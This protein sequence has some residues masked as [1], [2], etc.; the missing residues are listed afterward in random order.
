MATWRVLVGVTLALC[1]VVPAARG[2]ESNHRYQEGDP[3]KLW[4]NR[5]GP[6]HNPQ[7]TY[8]YYHLPFCRPPGKREHKWGG[9]GE[10]LEGNELIQSG[11][12]ITFQRDLPVTPICS[13]DVTE[14]VRKEFR[15]AVKE[16]YWYQM[17]FD[18]L[19]I[20][21]MVGELLEATE[22]KGPEP[23][24]FTHK[25]FSIAYNQ[26][27]IIEVNLTSENPQPLSSASKLDFTYQVRWVPT[28]KRF[29]AR[30]QRYLDYNFFEHQIH[31][32]SIFNSFMMVIFLTGLVSLILMRTLRN[33]YTRYTKDVDELDDLDHEITDESGWKL[34]H[35]DVFRTPA[36]PIFFAVLLGSGS[37][38][39]LTAFAVILTAIVGTLYMG[40]GSLTTSYIVCFSILSFAAGYAGGSWYSQA[41]GRS[42]IRVMVLTALFYP[43]VCFT[44]AFVLNFVAIAYHSLAALPFG[45]IVVMVMIWLFVSL[46]MC[47]FG[48]V[49]GRNWSGSVRLPCRVNPIPRPIPEKKWYLKPWVV[50]VLGGILPFGSIFIEMYFIFTSFWNYKFYYVYGFMLLVYVILVIVTVCVT[51]VSSYFLLN[52]EDYRWPWTSFLSAASTAVYVYAYAVYYFFMKTKMFGFFQTCFYFGYMG[53]F[54]IGLALMCGAIGYVGTRIFVG[55]IYRNIKSD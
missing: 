55:R 47:A 30:F 4:V 10:V 44:I 11:I 28:M 22:E 12:P 24:L 1:L 37:Q 35:G 23:L 5:V 38:L 20:W 51:I 49:M 40:R 9:L 42:W 32:F 17:Y 26:D 39:V 21:G 6:Y 33:D 31:W 13:L 2:D 46:P 27:R 7:E 34:V 16:H 3:V 29:G 19:P 48:T 45:S 18:D 50:T 14:K 36:H 41:G 53:M 25:S 15:H 54:C 8:N 43:A 52:A